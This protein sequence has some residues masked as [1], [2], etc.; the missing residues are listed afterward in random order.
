MPYLMPYLFHWKLIYSLASKPID[1]TKIDMLKKYHYIETK[2]NGEEPANKKKRK[3]AH[4]NDRLQLSRSR[5]TSDKRKQI[6]P[7]KRH[8]KIVDQSTEIEQISQQACNK[9]LLDT[10]YWE[11]KELEHIQ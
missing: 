4:Q 8:H 7:V 11:K 6:V 1:L 10:L 3:D 2:Y 9:Q 5:A